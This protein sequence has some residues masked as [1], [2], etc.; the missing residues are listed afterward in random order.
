MKI[1]STEK[2][3][4]RKRKLRE[5]SEKEAGE[6]KRISQMR[7]GEHRMIERAQALLAVYAGESGYQVAQRLGRDADVIYG[8]LDRF[9][10]QGLE[11]LYDRPRSG[12]PAEYNEEQRGECLALAQ[13]APQQLDLPFGYW[14]LDRLVEYINQRLGIPISRAQLARVLEAEGLRWYQEKTYFTERPDPDFA[15]KRGR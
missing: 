14:S 8:W 4:G 15:E 7:K 1:L 12:R 9:E 10:Q 6:L 11:G 5:M 2:R 13:T 3:M